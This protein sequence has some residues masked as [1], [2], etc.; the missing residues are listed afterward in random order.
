MLFQIFFEL[1]HEFFYLSYV[2]KVDALTFGI[3]I[4]ELH[5]RLFYAVILLIYDWTIS[6]LINAVI[7]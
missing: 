4:I 7:S 2:S 1:L 6:R 3:W 5:K